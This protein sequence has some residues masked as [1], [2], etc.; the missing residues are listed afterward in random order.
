VGHEETVGE[1]QRPGSRLEQPHRELS[2]PRDPLVGEAR[3]QEV[4]EV[5]R[6]HRAAEPSAGVVKRF[7]MVTDDDAHRR[8]RLDDQIEDADQHLE[9]VSAVVEEVAEEHQSRRDA[10]SF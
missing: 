8:R 9:S 10:S 1:E 3:V 5:R 6:A 4:A 7:V 2:R